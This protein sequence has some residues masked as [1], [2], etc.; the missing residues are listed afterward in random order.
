MK[1]IQTI[2]FLLIPVMLIAQNRHTTDSKRAIKFYEEG[3]SQYTLFNY[4]SAEELLLKAIQV[5]DDFIEPRL[6]LAELYASQEKNEKA[7]QMFEKAAKINP[8]FYPMMYYSKGKI[9][10]KIEQFSD[11]KESFTRL[12]A[13][14]KIPSGYIS[15]AKQLIENCDFAIEAMKH[16]VDF[17]PVNMGDS[18]NSVYNEY[19]P[20]LTADETIIIFT[21][22]VPK[23]DSH[24]RPVTQETNPDKIVRDLQTMMSLQKMF[25]EDFYASY[26]IDSTW[27]KAESLGYLLNSKDLNEGAQTMTADGQVMYFTAC[28]RAD[29]EGSCDIYKTVKMGNKWTEPVNIGPP[30]NTKSWEGQPSISADGRTLYF[31][32]RRAGGMG[33]EDIWVSYLKEDGNFTRPENP[34][35]SINTSGRESSPFIHHDNKTLYFASN[36]WTG[37]GEFDLFKSTKKQEGGWT[38]P[39]NLG[40]PIN[41]VRDEV[42]F[43]VSA[44]GKRAYYAS[45]RQAEKAKD[46]YMFELPEQIQ[47]NPVSYFKGR[48]FDAETG[49][50][51]SAQFELIDLE[52]QEVI[53]ESKSNAITGN[54]LVCIPVNKDYALNVSKTGYLFYS[55][56]FA[57]KGIHNVEEPYEKDIPM[58]P[59][60]EGQK[61]I[62]KNIFFAHDSYDLKNT[63]L[64]ELNKVIQFLQNNES[65]RIE[66]S[67]H[68]D[69]TGSSDYNL[70]L[71]E[72]RA[73]AVYNYLIG[74]GISKERMF[75]KGYGE[76]EP[77]SN[78]DTDEGRSENRRT[79]MK[80]IGID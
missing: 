33:K 42:G 64:V 15:E 61:I 5:D 28:R 35:D 67:G 45:D 52:S 53:M 22:L 49:H 18:V 12:L 80:I 79:E 74:N 16:P 29:S 25:Q 36:T 14:K 40:Y 68:T 70:K 21:R 60:R 38:T 24:G 39:M 20:S 32:S 72:H 66:I 56:N 59:I 44:S 77:V 54:F 63:S 41:S 10:M 6:I 26:S 1:F 9:E 51:L 8:G 76:T 31:L 4:S 34:G 27:T 17:D 2:F 46:I 11:A 19:W 65:L 23:T 48:I 57:L 7:I 3:Y 62:L 69:N 50:N 71:S 73:Q 75:Y 37:M 13:F 58:K 47:P 55:D 30:V 78:N 43:F